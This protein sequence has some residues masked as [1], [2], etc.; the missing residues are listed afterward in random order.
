M[1]GVVGCWLLLLGACDWRPAEV[2]RRSFACT[3]NQ[4]C[5]PGWVCRESLC[6]DAAAGGGR[7]GGGTAGGSAGGAAGG[8]AGGAAGGS[9]GGEAGGSA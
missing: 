7:A 3:S 9:A 1:R 2:D 5:G 6:V 4:E 8:S